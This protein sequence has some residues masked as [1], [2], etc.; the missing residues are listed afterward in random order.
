MT[1]FTE[2]E[3]CYTKYLD[4][5]LVKKIEDKEKKQGKSVSKKVKRLEV[6]GIFENKISLFCQKIIQKWQCWKKS[7]QRRHQKR[8]TS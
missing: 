2:N 4:I 1:Y 8:R 3:I 6:E 7:I 5:I